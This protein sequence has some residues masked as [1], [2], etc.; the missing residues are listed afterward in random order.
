M[1]L[2]LLKERN[3]I[4]IKYFVKSGGL[5]IVFY[6]TLAVRPVIF[7]KTSFSIEVFLPISLQE[8]L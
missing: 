7:F 1:H 5:L 3:Y 2:R 8:V 6:K 4:R